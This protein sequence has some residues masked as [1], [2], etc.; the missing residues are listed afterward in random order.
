MKRISLL[1]ATLVFSSSA[2][3]QPI[4]VRCKFSTGQVTEFDKGRPNTKRS[5]DFSDVIFDQIDIK[6]QTVRMIGNAGAETLPVVEGMN[7]VN[8]LEITGTG[9]LNVTTIFGIKN[10]NE[11]QF[12]VVHSRHVTLLS[13]GPLPSQYLGPCTRL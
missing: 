4:S 9:N 7:S 6:K 3:S 12:P 8:L 10:I 13:G 5:S 11:R 2:L 1:I